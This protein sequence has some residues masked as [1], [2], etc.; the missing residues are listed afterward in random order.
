[1]DCDGDAVLYL[2]EPAGNACH[3]PNRKSCFYRNLDG[4]L[5]QKVFEKEVVALC[6]MH[7]AVFLGL[8]DNEID[9]NTSRLLRGERNK[10][11][12]KVDSKIF[13]EFDELIGVINGT[14][15]H[16][17]ELELNEIY[18]WSLLPSVAFSRE[19]F[20]PASAFVRGFYEKVEGDI[21]ENI[22]EKRRNLF[23]S[24]EAENWTSLPYTAAH[25]VGNVASARGSQETVLEVLRIDIRKILA[26]KVRYRVVAELVE[27]EATELN[28]DLSS[29]VK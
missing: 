7:Y 3:V 2:V 9:S 17:L 29:L 19:L 26:D 24:F 6:K 1:M 27:R 18:Y 28:Y 5:T 10:L 14:H 22:K 16:P 4:T 21:I 11:L 15:P 23:M 13:S 25:L 8:R 12:K 20:D